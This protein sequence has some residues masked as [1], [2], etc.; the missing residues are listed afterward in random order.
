MLNGHYEGDSEIVL[1]HGTANSCTVRKARRQRPGGGSQEG[2]K[3][4]ELAMPCG[5]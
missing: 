1:K 4:T 2:D 3:R 5:R